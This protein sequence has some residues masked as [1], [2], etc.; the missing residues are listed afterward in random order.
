MRDIAAT[1]LTL[2]GISHIALLWFLD[3]D[4]MSLTGA[5]LGALYLIIGIGLYGQSRFA[6]FMAIIV[7]TGGAWL[8]L[9]EGSMIS[10][11]LLER[12]QLAI[13][14]VVIVISASVL[15]TVRNNPSA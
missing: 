11:N 15:F 1:L 9:R 5:L 3:I 8:A 14:L 12:T 10:F 2:S 13:A 4:A 7:P 6:L